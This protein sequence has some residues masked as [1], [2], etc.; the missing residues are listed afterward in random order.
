MTLVD[1]SLNPEESVLEKRLRKDG[2][3]NL[4]SAIGKRGRDKTEGNFFRSPSY[5]FFDDNMLTEL[6]TY[7]GLAARI[8]NRI[9]DDM[10][11]TWITVKNDKEG[12]IQEELKR[13]E[14][15]TIINRAIKWTRLYRGC[16]IV[17]LFEGD[18]S[19]LDTPAPLTIKGIS[20]LRIYSA[21]R[22]H[23]TTA[24]IVD[25]PKSP[26]FDEVEVFPVR[27]RNGA[28]M[29]VHASRCL[30]FKGLPVP[31]YDQILDFQYRY[32]GLPALV[33]IYER[34]SNYGVVEK[35][36]CSIMQEA[37]VGKYTM[38]NLASLLAQND[39][40]SLQLIYDRIDIIDTCKSAINAVLL[41]EGES[42]ERD[43][44]NFSGVE[45]IVDRM[46]MNLSAVSE[47]PV[48]ILFGRSPA[49]QNATGESDFQSYYDKVS[50][51]QDT[52]LFPPLKKLID[53][54]AVYT[55]VSDP[56]IEFNPLKEANEEQQAKIRKMNTE[57]DKMDIETGVYTPE[58]VVERRG[59]VDPEN[60]K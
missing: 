2:W 60:D 6:Y 59:E 55:K 24:D 16:I 19:A 3:A 31:D 35:G 29:N 33:P 25:D 28:I 4:F 40:E 22:V 32:W 53:Y 39:N 52:W 49:G 7:D 47:Y 45:G 37:V 9:A 26:Y 58:E 14:A 20:G 57:S 30:V 23:I 1:K 18:V 50:S 11:R 13:L 44:V 38:S 56:K 54:I 21:P 5:D 27:K 17:I 36:I 8:V 48:T 34:I 10:T 15:H 51:D 43:A 42:Y 41:G 12:K 46:M